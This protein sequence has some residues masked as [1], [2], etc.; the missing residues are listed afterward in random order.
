[1]VEDAMRGWIETALEDGLP[2][3]LPRPREA[4][5]GKFMVRMPKSLH[6]ELAEAAERE[7]VNLNAFI[8]MA[9]AKTVGQLAVNQPTPPT[10]L[11]QTPAHISHG[12]A[13]RSESQE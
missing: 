5:S 3:P 7:G 8:N 1:M 2:I 10:V 6:R 9:L 4:Y 12:V 11:Y 13:E